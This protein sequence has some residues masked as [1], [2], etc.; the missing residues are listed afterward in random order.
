[1]AAKLKT[2]TGFSEHSM[3]AIVSGNGLGLFNSSRYTLGASGAIGSGSVGVSGETA[4]VNIANGNL[5]LQHTDDFLAS[6][7]ADVGVLRTY[8]S[9]ATLSTGNWVIGPQRSVQDAGAGSRNQ[10]GARATRT[11]EDGSTEVFSFDAALG[12]YRSSDGSGAYD[13]LSYDAASQKW[14]FTDGATGAKE[15]YDGAASG[16][17]LSAT[18]A[19]GNRTDYTY[20]DGRLTQIR[21]A[22]GET[23]SFI[24]SG[25]DLME[26]RVE[27]PDLAG[28]AVTRV[29][30]EYD[31]LHR[32]T[33][34]TTDLTPQDGSVSDG[35][36]YWVSYG[37]DGTSSRINLVQD[38]DG[39]RLDITYVQ[40]GSDWRTKTLTDANGNQTRFDYDT[41]ARTTTVTDPLGLATVY[42]YDSQGQLTAV[43]PPPVD[44]Q[45]TSTSFGYDDKGNVVW[46]Q[47]ALNR[48]VSMSYDANGNLVEQRDAAGNTVRRTYDAN[49][50]LLTQTTYL[51]PDPDGAGAGQPSGALT[52][53]YVYDA[54][55]NLRFEISAQGDVTEYRYDSQGQ[56]VSAIGYTA[57]S[58]SLTGLAETGVPTLVQMQTWA[59]AIAD[60]S[61]TQRTDYQYDIRGQL[62]QMTRYGAVDATG[63]GKLDGTQT[64]TSYSYDS[65][66][67]LRS[68]QTGARIQ[69]YAY[70]GLGRVVLTTDAGINTS[71]VNYDDANRT[72]TTALPN[73]LTRTSVYDRTG[74]LLSVT[75]NSAAAGLGQTT[76]LYDADGRLRMS[77]SPTGR[78]NY[79]LYDVQGR[80]V[81]QVDPDGSLTENVFDAAG[82]LIKQVRYATRIDVS[83]LLDA[84]GKPANV[85]LATLRP[86]SSGDDRTSWNVYDAAGRLVRTIDAS[87]DVTENVYDGA[88]RL[89]AV[90]RYA[91]PLDVSALAAGATLDNTK[92]GTSADDR[93]TRIFF[94]AD[95][96]V[97]GTLDADGYLTENSY[98]A[99][100]R[101]VL[102]RRYSTVTAAALRAS[103]SLDQLRPAQVAASDVV[104]R[105]AYDGEGRLVA[106]I[107]A[108]GYL[109]RLSYDASGNVWT[110]ERYANRV[111]SFADTPVP[112]SED[113]L[114][115][116]Q[117]TARNQLELQTSYDGTETCY[118][119]DDAGN[120]VATDRAYG[121]SDVRRVL[122]RYDAQGRLV[123]ELGPEHAGLL[124]QA[125]SPAEI[126]AVFAQYAVT[127]GYDA[128][129]R[130]I[131]VSDA[132]Q[133][134]TY[135]YYNA[136]GQLAY[137]INAAGEVER[138]TYNAFNELETSTRYAARLG[139]T[140]LSALTGGTPDATLQALFDSLVNG[141]N[142]TVTTY[143]Y[144]KTGL[145]K[146]QQDALQFQSCFE[147]D[148]FG[149]LIKERRQVDAAGTNWQESRYTYDHRGDVM[150][151]VTDPSGLAITT[152]KT[153][154][155]FGR[156][157]S[158]VDAN[159]QLHT[160]EYD[161]LGR[162]VQTQDPLTPARVTTYDA[163]D[164][165]LTQKDPLGVLTTYTY[166]RVT[167]SV[168]ICTASGTA[169]AVTTR[170]VYNRFGQQY[171]VTDG[172]QNTTTY[173]YDN[174]GRITR[175]SD[176][177]GTLET[178]SYDALTGNL[179]EHTDAAGVVTRYVYDSVNR[180]FTRTIDPNGIAAT[181]VYQYDAKGQLL[182][183]TDPNGVVTRTQYDARGQ[184][185]SVIVDPAGFALTTSYTYDGVGNTLSVTDPNLN[186]VVY[187][188]DAAG[189]RTSDTVDPNGLALRTEYGYDAEGNVA[190][191]KDARGNY[192]RFV[193][194]A[195]G[196]LAY[197]IDPTGAIT[198]LQYDSDDRITSTTSYANTA[199]LAALG[200]PPTLTS[201][202]SE[203]G[204]IADSSR[205][206]V[207]M[208]YYDA[209]GR[210]RFTLDGAGVVTE[211]R[212][213]ENGNVLQR[214]SYATK[215]VGNVPANTA[216]MEKAVHGTAGAA[217]SIAD[218][219]HDRLTLNYFDARNRVTTTVDGT[220]AVKLFTYDGAGNVLWTY[221]YA[222]KIDS[223]QALADEADVRR[224]VLADVSHDQQ[225][226]L[227][228]DTAGR[229]ALSASALAC[230]ASGTLQWSVE[231]RALDAGGR[232][233]SVKRFFNSLSGASLASNPTQLEVAAWIV[234]VVPSTSA[235]AVE[236]TAY[237]AANRLVLSVDAVGAVTRNDYD[238]A[239]NLIEQTRYSN[240]VTLGDAETLDS[241]GAAIRPDAT[242]DRVTYAVFDAA[243]RARVSID[244]AG[245]VTE[246]TLDALG[247]RVGT[248][249]YATPKGTA[250]WTLDQGYTALVASGY[251]NWKSAHAN[252]LQDRTERAVFDADNQR[253]H[254]IDGLGYVTRTDYDGLGQIV[255]TIAFRLSLA[256]GVS[257]DAATVNA[258]VGVGADGTLPGDARVDRFTYDARGLLVASRDAMGATESYTYDGVGNKL[259][260]QNKNG[261]VWTY[262]YDARGNLLSEKSPSVAIDT[263]KEDSNGQLV[264]TETNAGVETR[265]TY[266]ALG[267]LTARTEAYGTDEARTTQYAYDAAGHQ[268]RVTYPSV[269]VYDAASDTVLSSGT[270]TE[271]LVPIYTETTYDALGRAVT[272]RDVGGNYS[273]RTYDQAGQLRY[274]VDATGGVTG[275]ELNAFGQNVRIT[276]F[277][278]QLDDPAARGGA[279]YV[280]SELDTRYLTAQG[281]PVTGRTITL[282]YDLAGHQIK[283]IEPQALIYDPTH[284][285]GSSGTVTAGKTTET[286]Y[287]AFGQ[288]IRTSVYGQDASGVVVSSA[289]STYTY[290]DLRGLQIATLTQVAAGQAYLTANWYDQ[291]G[292]LTQVT[293]YAA[294][295]TGSDTTWLSATP[296]AAPK[297]GPLQQDRTTVY[298]Y[299]LDNRKVSETRRQVLYAL[300]ATTAN[301]RSDLTTTYGYDAVGNQTRVT[302][303]LQQS[304]YT[305]YDA[306]G[307]KLAIVSPEVAGPN[308]VLVRP[309][310][311]FKLDVYGNVVQQTVFANGAMGS[312]ASGF[313]APTASSADRTTTMQYDLA[314]DLTRVTDP[315]QGDTFRS[316]DAFGR[317]AK[318]WKRFTD[319][320]GTQLVSYQQYTYD[321]LGRQTTVLTPATTAVLQELPAAYH[322]VIGDTAVATPTLKS[323]A[324]FTYGGSPGDTSVVS[325]SGTNT[326]Q[327]SFPA[328]VPGATVQIVLKYHTGV[329]G[330]PGSDPY[331]PGTDTTQ[332]F[333]ATTTDGKSV[334]L[335]WPDN[336]IPFGGISAVTGF[337]LNVHDVSG[338]WVQKY[339]ATQSQLSDDKAQ[340]VSQT[341][342]VAG[343]TRSETVYNVYGEVTQRLVNGQIVEEDEYNTAGQI[344]RTTGSD[345]VTRGLLHDVSGNVTAEIRSA[346]NLV[347]TAIDE[348]DVAALRASQTTT[349]TRYDLMGRAIAQIFPTRAAAA[350]AAGPATVTGLTWSIKSGSAAV[351]PAN[352]DTSYGQYPIIYASYGGSSG[353]ANRVD[354]QWTSLAGLGNGDVSVHIEYRDAVGR[355]LVEER[356][357]RAED[358]ATGAALYWTSTD[359]AQTVTHVVVS[360]KDLTGNWV[361]VIDRSAQG[362][363]GN[364]I[365][366]QATPGTNDLDASTPQVTVLYRLQGTSGWSTAT[367]AKGSLKNFGNSYLFSPTE[368]LSGTYEY[369]VW[370]AAS[371]QSAAT[372]HD[373]GTMTLAASALAIGGAA[374]FSQSASS[375]LSWADPGSGQTEIFRYRVQGTSSWKQLAVS[376]LGSGRLGVNVAGLPD[377]AYEYELLYYTS[378]NPNPTAHATGVFTARGAKAATQQQVVVNPTTGALGAGKATQARE[379]AWAQPSGTAVTP[380]FHYRPTGTTTWIELP[381]L[382]QGTQY[383]VDTTALAAGNYDYEIYYRNASDT[384][385][386]A[387]AGGTMTMGASGTSSISPV[388]G[389]VANASGPEL[390]VSNT[391]VTEKDG[392]AV[393]TVGASAAVSASTNVSLALVAGTATSADYGSALEI[394][395]DNGNTWTN[396]NQG[397]LTSTRSS[398]LVRTQ[399]VDDTQLESNESFSLQATAAY[400]GTTNT[401]AVG[402]AVIIDD[403]LFP[404]L[405]VSNA[406]VAEGG[407]L[408][409][410]LNLSRA[411]NV[412]TTVNLNLNSGTAVLG[413]DFASRIDISTD[414]GATWI[415]DV[416]SA[417]FAAGATAIKARVQT[418]SDA[419]SEGNETFTLTASAS[420]GTLNPSATGVGTIVDTSLPA[421]TM[422]AVT[423]D[424]T[425]GTATFNVTMSG[426][427]SRTV[428]VNFAT[429]NGTAVAGADYIAT[430][431]TLSFAPGETTQSVTVVILDDN[432]YEGAA[433]ETFLLNLS[434][435]LYAALGTSFVTGS[436][437]DNERAPTL[438]VSN[439]SATEGGYAVFDLG[440]SSVSAIA[441]TVGLALY[442][443]TAELGSD[444]NNGVEVSYD[445][446]LTWSGNVSNATFAA[447]TTSLKAR[448]QTLFDSVSE[449][450]ETFTL[451]AVPYSGTANGTVNATATIVDTSKPS[452]NVGNVSVSETA[453]TATFTVSLSNPSTSAVTVNFATADGTAI[454]G[455]D[456]S[457]TS[458]TLTFAPGETS[459]TV[460]VAIL[461]DNLYESSTPETFL[462]NLSSPT[463]ATLGANGTGS[464][465]DGEAPPRLTVSNASVDEGGYAVFDLGLSGPSSAPTTVGLSLYG[466]SA[467]M[468][469]D[470]DSLIQ[471]STDGGAT[472]SSS[473]TSAT[474]AAG[475]TAMKAR[476]HTYTDNVSEGNETFTLTATA[477]SGTMYPSAVGTG[478][479]VDVSRP[480]VNVGAVSV[481]EGA[482]TATFTV[483]LSNPSTSTVTVNFATA[484]GTAIA[485]ADYTA[486]SGT[487]TFAPGETSKTVTVAILDDNLY[488]GPTPET[489]LLTLTSPSNATLG[490]SAAVGS[491]TDNEGLPAISAGNVSVSET[492]GTATFTVSLSNPST[493]AVTV[494]FA[495]A[496][497]TA[498]AGADYTAT[499][500]TLTFA[501]GETSK[502]V[503]VAILDDNI[504]EGSTPETFLLNLS[505]PTNAI[506][507]ANGTGS[508][509]DGEAPPWLTVSNASVDEGGYAV[510]DLGLSGPSSAPTT[511]GL[512]LYGG[513]ATMSTD[514]DNAIQVSTDGGVT[515]SSSV[516]SATF[517][518]GAIAMKARVHTATDNVSEGNE[519]FTLTATA[520]SGTMYPS[521]TGTGTIVDTSKPSVSVGNV[522]VNEST[523][524]ATFTVTLSN[525]STSVVTV[526]FATANGTAIAGLDY[527]ATSGTLT[528]AAGETSKTVSVAILNDTLYE[529]S[530]PETFAL[531]LSS[532]S[533][534]TLGTATATG[535][536]IDNEVAPTLTVSNASVAESSYVVFDLGLSGPSSTAVTVGLSLTGGTATLGTDF[537]NA[538]QI[539]TDGG[540]TWSGNVTSAT[541]AAGTTALKARVPTLS[542]GVSEG[543]ETFSLVATSSSGTSNTSATGVG[544][545]VDTSQPAIYTNA[546]AVNEGAG[547]A[548]FTVSLSNPSTSTVTV[549]FTTANGT[550]IA[551]SDYTATS[552]TLT[553]APGETSKTVSVAILDD[554]LYEGSTAETFLL[555]LSSPTNAT[556]GTSSAI[557]MIADNDPV[558]LV[559]VS[560]ASGNEGGY[561]YFD[562]GLSG[563][564]SAPTTVGLQLYGGT[565]T[566]GTDFNNVIE[567][568]ADG[569]ATW[570]G[571]V[572]S[573]TI[574]AGSTSLKARV[575]T[576]GDNVSEGNETFTLQAVTGNTATGTGTI[577][578]TSKPSINVGN[579][580]VSETAGTATFTVSLSNP[581]TSAVTVNFATANGTAIAGADY[582]AT[583][584]TLTFAAGETSKTVTVAILDDN[585]YEG[586]TPE[587]FLLNLSSPTNATL[588]ANGTGSIVDGEAPPWLTVSNASVDEGGYA[589]FDLGLSG[590]SSV[591]TTVGLSLYGGSATLGTDFDSLIQVSTDGGAT[592]SSSV[593][594]ATFAAGATAMKARVHTYTDNVSEG[595]ETFTLTA[596]ASS[597]TMYPSA[598]GTGT[599]VD[600]SRPT[601]NVSGVSV[602][603]SAGTATFTVSLSNPSTS[604]VTVNF[605][606]A[607][608]TAIAGADYTGVSGSLSF[609]PGETSKTVSVA[610]LNDTLYEGATPETFSLNLTSPTNATLGSASA[611]GSIVEDDAAPTLTVSSASVAEGGYAVFDLGLSA[612][613][614]LPTVVGLSLS[615]GTATLGTDFSNAIQIST[616][617][618]GTWSGN[619]TSATFVAGTTTLKARVQTLTDGVSDGSE[620]FSLV[621][622]SSGTSNASA[623]GVGTIVDTSRPT[624]NVGGATVNEGAGTASF[625]VTLS[626]PST[627]TV[628]VNFATTNGT[629]VEGLDYTTASGT[630]TFAPGE[631][632][633]VVTVAIIDDNF[634]EG[635][636]PETF[637][638]NLSSPT[639]AAL[640]TSSA[641]GTIVDN[642]SAPTL[643]VSNTSATEG[644]LMYFDVGLSAP[645]NFP[646]T[647]ALQLYGG[648]ATLGTDF[649][650]SFQ[651]SSD[652][653]K[654][655][656][657]GT[658]AT[659][660][661]GATSLKVAVLTFG[662]NISEGNE[663][664]TLTAVANSGTN[665]VTATG[666]G[667]IIDTSKPSV[668]VGNISVNEYAGT[669]TFTVALSN[670]STS[671]ITVDYATANGTAIAG[672]DYTATSGT[673]SFAP[674]ET[675]KTVSVAILDDSLYEGAETF[676]LNLGNPANATLAVGSATGSIVD[677][678][679]APTVAVSNASVA[680]G[681]YEVFDVTLTGPSASPITVGLSLGGYSATLGSDFSN[682]IQVSTDGGTTWSGNVTAATFA[683]G[684]TAF[685]ARVQTLTDSVSE[686]SETFGL[687]V[688]PSS[689][690]SN[691]SATGTGT[692][693]DTSQPVASVSA[694]TVGEAAGTAVFTVTLS[695]PSASTV[696]VNYATSDGTAIAGSDYVAASG[697]LSF[698]PGETSK[699][700]SVAIIN[701]TLYEGSTN[702]AF[703]LDLTSASNATL[704]FWATT[705]SIVDDD[706][707]P[708]I[709]INDMSVGEAAGTATFTVSLSNP[710]ASAV[711][712]NYATANGTATAGSDYTAK[713][714][715][716]TF[717]AGVTSQTVSV[718][719]INDTKYEGTTPE[720]YYVNLS[721]AVGGTIIDSQG[722]GYIVDNDPYGSL[723]AQTMSLMSLSTGLSSD[724][725]VSSL[726]VGTQD[727]ALAQTVVAQTQ[728][729]YGGSATDSLIGI[730]TVEPFLQSV[731]SWDAPAGADAASSVFRYREQG[732]YDWITAPISL[733]NGK[734]SATVASPGMGVVEYDVSFRTAGS[735]DEFSYAAGEIL[736]GD[737]AL[738]SVSEDTG[739]RAATQS[740]AAQDAFYWATTT[741]LA[742][743]VAISLPDAGLANASLSSS[744]ANKNVTPE[745]DFTLDRWGNRIAV[746]DVRNANWL[747]E[748]SYDENNNVVQTMH[749][750]YGGHVVDASQTYYD[751]LGRQV[752][753]SD[754]MGHTNWRTLDAAGNVTAEL[755]ADGG[756]VSNAYD[757]FG[758]LVGQVDA[759]GRI[760]TYT[761]DKLGEML[762]RTVGQ[763]ATAS[764][765]TIGSWFAPQGWNVMTLQTTTDTITTTYTYDAL[766]HRITED[767]GAGDITRYRYDAAGN[768]TG[769]RAPT[770][771][772]SV[773]YAYNAAGLKV[774]EVDG[775]GYYQ[776]WNFDATGRLLSS[777]ELGGATLT[778]NY[779]GLG[780]LTL[781]TRTV[782]LKS[783]ETWY[784]YDNAGQVLRIADQA[785]NTLTEYS[786]DASGRHVTERTTVGGQVQGL[787]D[788]YGGRVVQDNYIG[789]DELGQ[790]RYVADGVHYMT[791]DYDLAGNR[792]HVATRYINDSGTQRNYDYWY[793]YDAMNRQV[794]VDGVRNA[795]T[796]LVDVAI[797]QGHRLTYD[798]T[799]NRTSDVTY[800]REAYLSPSTTTLYGGGTS[801]D[802]VWKTEEGFTTEI[803]AYDAAGRLTT[804]TRDGV[805]VDQRVYDAAGRV[806]QSGATPT[807]A[808]RALWNNADNKWEESSQVTQ[809]RYDADGRVV[810]EKL[811]GLD[812]TTLQQTLEDY[813]YDDAGNLMSYKL[814]SHQGSGFTNTYTNTYQRFASYKQASQAGTSTTF[815]PGETDY[816]F[817]AEGN[818]I[819]VTDQKASINDRQFANDLA[820]RVLEKISFSTDNGVRVTHRE[821]GMIVNGEYLGESGDDAT[822]ATRTGVDGTRT[823]GAF[824]LAWKQIDASYPG[825]G[826]G[827]Y[828]VAAGDTLQ[829]IAKSAYGDAS[830]WYR[831]AEANGLNFNS[832]LNVGQVLKLPAAVG[833]SN[834]AGTYNPYDP[835]SRIGD[836]N[837]TMPTP[838]TSNACGTAGMILMIVVVVVVSIFTAGAAALALAGEGA[839][840][841]ATFGGI[842]AAGGTVMTGGTIA[843]ATVGGSLMAGSMA[844]AAVGGAVG[845]MAG[846]GMAMAAGMQD[847]FSWR[848]VGLGALTAAVGS[849][850]G[851]ALGGGEA[852]QLAQDVDPVTNATTLRLVG[853]SGQT[854]GSALT[855]EQ[856]A[857][858]MG[859]TVL[860]STVSGAVAQGLQGRWNWRSIAASAI[861]SAAGYVAGQAG[862]AAADSLFAETKMV[863]SVAT[864]VTPAFARALTSGT[865]AGIAQNLTM[866]SF[867]GGKLNYG[868][869]VADAFGNAFGQSVA[870]SSTTPTS[871]EQKQS[872]AR[873]QE[874]SDTAGATLATRTTSLAPTPIAGDQAAVE[875]ARVNADSART[876][877][878]FSDPM[879]EFIDTMMPYWDARD[880]IPESQRS[881]IDPNLYPQAAGQLADGRTWKQYSTE[882][883]GSVA[884]YDVQTQS[885]G[886]RELAPHT[887]GWGAQVQAYTPSVLGTLTNWFG[888]YTSGQVGFSDAVAGALHQLNVDYRVTQRIS[889]IRDN[890]VEP[891][892]TGIN[893]ASD[894]TGWG[895]A[896]G[897]GKK[898]VETASELGNMSFTTIA[899]A[900]LGPIEQ[901]PLVRDTI[902]QYAD[903]HT[904]HP[905]YLSDQMLGRGLGY[906]ATFFGPEGAEA[907]AARGAQF[908]SDGVSAGARIL[909]DFGATDYNIAWR[910]FQ[911]GT[912]YSNP[913]PF[914]LQP[915]ESAVGNVDS[916]VTTSLAELRAQYGVNEANLKVEAT[917]EHQGNTFYDVN[918]T[919]R[920]SELATDGRLPIYSDAK[921]SV[922]APNQTYADAHAEIGAMAQSFDTG[923]R[924]GSATLTIMGKDACSFC[925]SDVKRMALQLELDELTVIQPS[926]TITFTGPQDFAPIKLGGKK[927]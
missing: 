442:G 903:A 185:K 838:D 829:S 345:G 685:K 365:V 376:N 403:D 287:N 539:S 397:S 306:L 132:K 4:S 804:T 752:G 5:V 706:A 32:L 180:L 301:T 569:G 677:N 258:A 122:E 775:N 235:D 128:D 192:T 448:V 226:R 544:T 250:T 206:R 41:V 527:T 629:A 624:I 320:D 330:T 161:R 77:Q 39:T 493:S 634:Y 143:F 162:V 647:V 420:T 78:R 755:H 52:S 461:D 91:T 774:A 515:W 139:G 429:A 141:S 565:A 127:Y 594:S 338:N 830:Q 196:R 510:F 901:L 11:D 467:T 613:S 537:S 69:T 240:R 645:S 136:D 687:T 455:A 545:I 915:L 334:L 17:L 400:G 769:T 239:G 452:I 798:K 238:K 417:T 689:G 390:Y 443:G 371:G 551:G 469:T 181:T 859:G 352:Y 573:A 723:S 309:Y 49:N 705:G 324:V 818:L 367:V 806:L 379:I 776:T 840:G 476:V 184:V 118:Q 13:T 497:G 174:A 151:A 117:Y 101:L 134:K 388:H 152:T 73:G 144:T 271:H 466:G 744:G 169:D 668:S 925:V 157:V 248:T 868:A 732:S 439:A 337:T 441:T 750:T 298:A 335:S 146:T 902:Q 900:Y 767:D 450:N 502:T 209:Q 612:P 623:A 20:S 520:S 229:L 460:T 766:G 893:R 914:E 554:S 807:A 148:A 588:G 236:H 619:V 596:T 889:G 67:Y 715:T 374:D 395:Y 153:Y 56:L 409:F 89:V 459:K 589:V 47:D 357:F 709:S 100:G 88:S 347:H 872:A 678:E 548:T 12:L 869:I 681:G 837:P 343:S 167:R 737:G 671:W 606:T 547:T 432:L 354:L 895:T 474:F 310:T 778:Y 314:G 311:Q 819:G 711:S 661:P 28:G 853:T 358:A 430:S 168:T 514:F 513:T 879:G 793:A 561:V 377:G 697:A 7:G 509:V 703:R 296:P 204:R 332:T 512:S 684:T 44:G 156:V 679:P 733:A 252:A 586:S 907:V 221:A 828:T 99:A 83:Q 438:S 364:R 881:F 222:N 66:G 724:A 485:G 304:T 888:G 190:W 402:E 894:A 570:S 40:V 533:N 383:A 848:Q 820:G 873:A 489:F 899:K 210:V 313:T 691:A 249:A 269:S 267:N 922:G 803:Y 835:M 61:Q 227:V 26:V 876:G 90:V 119:Y 701:D 124:A 278:A 572:S 257:L 897:F 112:N 784:R 422:G 765:V 24:Y 368:A 75:E 319:I 342:A 816:S 366:F 268:V 734:M 832:T 123:A 680:E 286:T 824:D 745:M 599:I 575:L 910:Q 809:T 82:E 413:A 468:G 125:S 812:G 353:V 386:L 528:F 814:V 327:V 579:V 505:S 419:V 632:S 265:M 431:G 200:V 521:A 506:L 254:A 926:G 625:T 615:G 717:A 762:T 640:G 712:V 446:G 216:E 886:R 423:V 921:A 740:V 799:G 458:G 346:A 741:T 424:E 34:V 437:V 652:G 396:A 725:S 656:S 916:S 891:F 389:Y 58:Y 241:I 55:R 350:G 568:S 639:N 718:S 394:S 104:T 536:I 504:Y 665:N 380:H 408:F 601:I 503:T 177:L 86:Q 9:Q 129:G 496:N 336:A 850:V 215:L 519:S 87:G 225:T 699:T 188:Y 649:N 378:G 887:D 911:P 905:E 427:S 754:A 208:S 25:A 277:D 223:P 904:Y 207:A 233:T 480:S 546:I 498:I 747:T 479:I 795:A 454:A 675:S 913:V 494:N 470:F 597:G 534:A 722:I 541:F 628:T 182:D 356:E 259:T 553:F 580:S 37:Y 214:I 756:V 783:Y 688:T 557:G 81:G 721:S 244:A 694:V 748:Y 909:R 892:R 517:A 663:T 262:D 363:Y 810:A 415:Q 620:T 789:Y 38:K 560:N 449:G 247:N 676:F 571:N 592:W 115:T 284:V 154:D 912:L 581:S 651:I 197:T 329:Y 730:P 584:G 434:S 811:Y 918:Q 297:S 303:A 211:Q 508:I 735:T 516:T 283:S 736:V 176:G 566:L 641:T 425:A 193:Y 874:W 6:L 272:N 821:R 175:I 212:F 856:F 328:L 16:N 664:V 815:D 307:R 237:D 920:N 863:G 667:T 642:D 220:G 412:A 453:G 576:L 93:T 788:Y 312:A 896:I 790:M 646:T 72:V 110:R 638:L 360:K 482:G 791:I 501:A 585:I 149:E 326:V 923:A 813:T 714:G 194:D 507:G 135:Y 451:Q 231:A 35:Q 622:T 805:V 674:G 927:W 53:R 349:E 253:T 654:T 339:T 246:Y 713:S 610:I 147:Y 370:Y 865:A 405:T 293:E 102:T 178:D 843:G 500:G 603:E 574:A 15:T 201:V 857:T 8:N 772:M 602:S 908:V 483:S 290:Y 885:M 318:Q 126:D 391:S 608:G 30:Y 54:N 867:Q 416:T 1:L 693:V 351:P 524:T 36:S 700:I 549:N 587:T 43:T 851:G 822:E 279:P 305:Y 331:A 659:F 48:R 340:V 749:S 562:V 191:R 68:K 648:T 564:S 491:V 582:T 256:N 98:D 877:R 780:D 187:A 727:T 849:G 97:L 373:T 760:T 518:A 698:A 882:N 29:R 672:A 759:E 42:G 522:S 270:R 106:T 650:S 457:A 260:Y 600:T 63:Q 274:E 862:G 433:P 763:S 183:V 228:Y 917:F 797:D 475:T 59:S 540:T 22:S 51:V 878:S 232:V 242:N 481:N 133:Q 764:G 243:N 919:A 155:A 604:T 817:D 543:N 864:Q 372:A 50:D 770:G 172:R 578:D 827:A 160:T 635:P 84:S 263:V 291:V 114:T 773:Q 76:Y 852:M 276:R 64:A 583:S 46:V 308:G 323:G 880:G 282:V 120:L 542:D 636:T 166:D 80:Q 435:P 173:E 280:T 595:N 407:V 621:A 738:P 842:M 18:D 473:V 669:G 440:L 839:L 79:Y 85:S 834:N 757:I 670:P 567:V 421:I 399:I 107:D 255:A 662:D 655:W 65:F 205:D 511:V 836:T 633:K 74:A 10:A 696:T 753:T 447:G 855:A 598:T 322:A 845:S 844:A 614:T 801:T 833:A 768:L 690:T 198:A 23:T 21:D 382:V 720:T 870:A 159:Q 779:D 728:S 854:A 860:R 792:T 525:P 348:A 95:G 281:T 704:G 406:S 630:L 60:K 275:Y 591:P 392:Y 692:I 802:M 92:P 219:T 171:Q 261:A 411:T 113:E 234:K 627:S 381:V 794:V 847:Q 186:V 761:Y 484:D 71:I 108:E 130:R 550:A 317:V 199:N 883:D 426:A 526:S 487:L 2:N 33:K 653:G 195:K 300:T 158:L 831:I 609:A 535:S 445:G 708:R 111:T 109:T 164:R 644:N 316:Y 472:W 179:F 786:Y 787:D 213:D 492:A 719:I 858:N 710:S 796:G 742:G 315:S 341:Q 739:P 203:I 138:R 555:N 683:A 898:V 637:L 563:L 131:W 532:P 729:V 702:E 631:T 657:A 463:N 251:S 866:Q 924:G 751:E 658:S 140:A 96:R 841:S 666:T 436:I 777:R 362:N 165:V 410:D 142:D 618:G 288:A 559:S 31:A 224:H 359:A 616:D 782:G 530:T 289:S 558:P 686:G 294:A 444:F 94:D 401:S 189:R 731:V 464:I 605:A 490:T 906:G 145:V 428:T 471:V 826:P 781:A 538:I 785:S 486:T 577:V 758:D 695:N 385:E 121:T 743:E 478:T 414:G 105:N 321:A 27:R 707:A 771:E 384:T 230:D 746:T 523:G 361:T 626:N 499:S 245:A 218:A 552:G 726:S 264:V 369:Q 292:N 273:Y 3:V 823:D 295:V 465:V 607:N 825:A 495:T 556:L 617:G 170:I 673:L 325:W 302:N 846:Q 593:V 660:T 62:A 643:T 418:V 682:A 590:P 19:N 387:R 884:V 355:N 116:Y 488:E 57:Q 333:T 299:D 150:T 103:G 217:G 611:T 808:Q 875:A 137:S 871:Q 456:Y 861:G 14:T 477:S 285:S 375:I 529:G 404:A 890:L 531:T 393:F 45:S 398:F 800:G 202:A 462:L 266:D 716:L 70:D 163:F 344:W